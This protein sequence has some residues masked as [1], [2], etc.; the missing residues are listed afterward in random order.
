MSTCRAPLLM[1]RETSGPLGR[2][3]TI[4]ADGL[5]SVEVDARTSEECVREAT[6][7]IEALALEAHINLNTYGITSEVEP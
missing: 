2:H 4:R 7:S 1:Y 3:A 5:P 6:A